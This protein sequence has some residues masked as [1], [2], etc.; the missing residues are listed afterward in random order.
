MSPAPDFSNVLSVCGAL[1]S[2]LSPWSC[3]NRGLYCLRL[4]ELERCINFLSYFLWKTMMR[5]FIIRE[6]ISFRSLN[7]L[8][9]LAIVVHASYS[10]LVQINLF[11][12]IM[13]LTGIVTTVRSGNPLDPQNWLL[14]S[15]IKPKSLTFLLMT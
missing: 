11:F 6:W 4:T 7:A 2:F 13:F 14:L 12:R 15:I 5:R 10:P 9:P 1:S 8:K 3:F